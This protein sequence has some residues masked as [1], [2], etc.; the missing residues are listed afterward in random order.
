MSKEDTAGGGGGPQSGERRS[1]D[2]QEVRELLADKE[3]QV[4]RPMRSRQTHTVAHVETL[5]LTL[6]LLSSTGAR[7]KS[8]SCEE[9]VC[10][11]VKEAE[12]SQ[13]R[14]LKNQLQDKEDMRG[15]ERSEI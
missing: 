7:L 1:A 14:A 2:K 5:T 13:K 11:Q 8:A 9:E 4:I 6:T 3:Q 12:E 10:K 15:Q